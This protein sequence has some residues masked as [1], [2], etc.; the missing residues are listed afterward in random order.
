MV[1]DSQLRRHLHA[2]EKVLT[3]RASLQR[4]GK[5]LSMVG[6]AGEDYLGIVRKSWRRAVPRTEGYDFLAPVIKNGR[7]VRH[8]GAL[9]RLK[10]GIV[11]RKGGI[12]YEKIEVKTLTNK[13]VAA[14]KMFLSIKEGHWKNQIADK[15]FV[16]STQGI[17]SANA[18]DL[19]RFVTT[20]MKT[21]PTATSLSYQ[22]P[23]MVQFSLDRLIDLKILQPE[24]INP[25]EFQEFLKEQAKKKLSTGESKQGP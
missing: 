8:T 11:R 22:A 17:W 24:N 16:V 15:V 13:E 18:T 10:G 5:Y 23:L 25:V 1:I 9:V 6:L 2:S 19:R 14:G 4:M 21:L 20:H 3:R 7:R 12:V